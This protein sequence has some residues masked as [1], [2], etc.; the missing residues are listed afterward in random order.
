MALCTTQRAYSADEEK[1]A[2]KLYTGDN[3]AK[4]RDALQNQE[5]GKQKLG[6]V[7]GK[8][9]NKLYTSVFL[10]M[11]YVNGKITE[12]KLS[13]NVE[14]L[15]TDLVTI[16]TFSETENKNDYGILVSKLSLQDL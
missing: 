3:L 15:N 7:F 13:V 8:S 16:G 5:F 6:D 2:T 9:P 10:E 12:I 11:K 4:I 1:I 14:E